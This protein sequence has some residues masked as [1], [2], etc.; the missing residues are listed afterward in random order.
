MPVTDQDDE[1]MLTFRH[2]AVGGYYVSA[3]HSGDMVYLPVAELLSLLYIHNEKGATG[4]SLKGTYPD[5][6]PWELDPGQLMARSGRRDYPLSPED[7]RIGAMDLFLAPEIFEQLFGLVFTVNLSALSLSLQSEH[8]LP[9]EDRN[10]RD[11]LR[12]D[13]ERRRSDRPDYPLYFPRDRKLF[14]AGMLDYSLGMILNN[15]GESM[16]YNILGGL[17]FLGGDLQGGVNGFVNENNSRTNMS[18]LHWRY[19]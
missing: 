16:N 11:R 4:F 1:F 3:I 17:E 13:L 12:R 5:D 7:I 10:K 6:T 19:A 9:V 15:A 14:G 18:N 2:P 8:P